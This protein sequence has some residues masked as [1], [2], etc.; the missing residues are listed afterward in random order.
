M[1]SCKALQTAIRRKA[2]KEIFKIAVKN[3]QRLGYIFPRNKVL[4]RNQSAFNPSYSNYIIEYQYN[5]IIIHN[6]VKSLIFLY[7][8]KIYKFVKH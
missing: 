5:N 3:I 1:T 4:L 8:I 6:F 2:Y 7:L